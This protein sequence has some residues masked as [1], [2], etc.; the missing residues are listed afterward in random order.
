MGD[1]LSFCIVSRRA[2]GLTIPVRWTP[3]TSLPFV[4]FCRKNTL[5]KRKGLTICV[6]GESI[7]MWMGL[8]GV[9]PVLYSELFLNDFVE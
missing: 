3:R 5:L 6:N 2:D 9:F 7:S 8:S 1:P 4:K